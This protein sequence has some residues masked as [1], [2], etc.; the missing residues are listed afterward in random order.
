MLPFF[1]FRCSLTI[2]KKVA[3]QFVFY[4]DFTSV[5]SLSTLILLFVFVRA[6]RALEVGCELFFIYLAMEYD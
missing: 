3:I 1:D 4:F 5:P 2:L 6:F